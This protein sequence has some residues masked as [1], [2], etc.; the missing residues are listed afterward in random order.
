MEGG[1]MNSE[2]EGYIDEYK[3]AQEKIKIKKEALDLLK[4]RM[5]ILK[6]ETKD[7]LK[8]LK[9]Y[10]KDK[11]IYINLGDILNE[12]SKIK[13]IPLENLNVSA[14][15]S[16]VNSGGRNGSHF[17]YDLEKSDFLKFNEG[18]L[19]VLITDRFD[20]FDTKFAFNCFLTDIQSDDKT[21]LDHMILRKY[22]SEIDY[23]YY[24][25]NISYSSLALD[26]KSAE[27]INCRFSLNQ[28]MDY[29][30]NSDV[31][32]KAVLNAMNKSKEK[33]LVK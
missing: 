31:F 27:F 28:I 10:G 24:M 16:S 19:N 20:N 22:E 13:N 12:I 14:Y 17:K 26:E 30:N 33:V 9:K 29:Q 18:I 5:S 7:D 32:S 23:N 8:S 15:F 6:K 1:F 25:S 4:Q 3:K 11:F 21:L 2:F